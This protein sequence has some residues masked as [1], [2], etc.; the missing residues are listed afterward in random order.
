MLITREYDYALRVL[1]ALSPG[2]RNT[3][4]QI[5]EMEHIP[6]PYAY[7][8]LKKLE[9]ASLVTPYRGVQGG[10]EL[11]V[12]LSEVSLYDVYAAIEGPLYFNECMQE[13]YR[14]PNNEKGR[15]CA[16]HK[17]LS[18]MQNQFIEQMKTRRLADV[19]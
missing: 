16:V 8:I 9:K 12:D 2:E 6:Q 3:V 1:R 11:S 18:V 4:G 10:Y 15:R 17:E 13:E 14:C 19:L 5:C 7:K